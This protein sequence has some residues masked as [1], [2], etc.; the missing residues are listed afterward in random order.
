MRRFPLVVLALTLALS[1]GCGADPRDEGG[2]AVEPIPEQRPSPVEESTGEPAPARPLRAQSDRRVTTSDAPSAS[3][4][5]VTVEPFR[6]VPGGALLVARELGRGWRVTSTGAERGRFVSECQRVSLVDIGALSS[7]IREFAGAGTS[8]RQAVSRF[9][10]GRSAWRA[11]RVL[12]AW[13]EEC[14]AALR[15]RGAALGTV[16]RQGKLSVVEI[17]GV[18]RPA[19]RLER[20]LSRARDRLA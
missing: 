17:E 12:T 19:R 2:R 16:R 6:T 15:R 5:E 20:V 9:A 18:A 14:A 8:A 7:R 11:D 4:P 13:R 10:D 3:A 1:A